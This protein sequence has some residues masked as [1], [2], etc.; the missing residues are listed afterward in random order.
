MSTATR[1]YALN[2]FRL[3][4]RDRLL[5]PLAVAYYVTGQ[6]NLNCTYCEDF[7]QRRNAQAVLPLPLED[8][9]RVLSVIRSGVDRLILTG[10][11]PLLYPDIIPLT[12]RA[13]RELRF[14]HI[15][16]QTNGL[17]LS[18]QEALLP[19]IDRLVISLDSTD[20][21]LWSS[22]VNV[23]LETAQTI[24]DNVRAYARR[25][26]EFGYL[27]IAN[28]VLAPETLPGAGQVLDF[29][30][31]HGL[32][33]SLSPQ[34]V[35][36]WPHYELL[37]SDEYRAFLQGLVTLKR[38]GAPI[39]GSAAYL[40][41]LIDLRPFSCYPALVPRIMPNGELVYPCWPIEKAGTS[42]GGRPCNLLAV[43]SWTEVARIAAQ[44]YG[45]PPRVCT[46]CFQQCFA[47]PSLMQA[48]PLSLLYES[49]RHRA[50]RRGGLAGYAPG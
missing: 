37:V 7:G 21:N 30:T 1:N 20:P 41:T 29:C 14:R 19:A 22:I 35:N 49:L 10:G 11:D 40:R 46:S 3:L 27:M 24:L 17:L 15:T 16:L 39:L 25:Q 6:C 23:P 12:L 9:L 45:S 18:Q 36:N 5:R 33:F 43:G 48:K 42:H 28:C 47:E 13:R 34:A 50:S 26:R 32:L 8:A 31:E 4:R 2:L 38:R 44:E